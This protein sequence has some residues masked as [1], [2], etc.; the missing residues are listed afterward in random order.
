MVRYTDSA[1]RGPDLETIQTQD[2]PGYL[3]DYERYP[4]YG[5]WA[6]LEKPGLEFVGWFLFRPIGD[7][8]YFDPAWS[9]PDDIEL[10]Y[11][12]KRS[13]WGKGYASEGAAALLEKGFGELETERVIALVIGANVA[14]VR[15]L[16]KVGLQIERVV[17]D[18]KSPEELRVYA[19]NRD[20]FL[21][22]RNR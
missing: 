10:G 15:V 11:R 3:A 13:A 12:L 19:L 14:S 18:P 5:I 7:A 2:L 4:H 16:E 20:A 21:A 22:A 17:I 8:R 9:D 6:A 1:G